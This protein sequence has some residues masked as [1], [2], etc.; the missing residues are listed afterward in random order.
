LV[1]CLTKLSFYLHSSRNEKGCNH[2][3]STGQEIRVGVEERG[4]P[5]IGHHQV[6]QTAVSRLIHRRCHGAARKK[7]D[8][9]TGLPITYK[10]VIYDSI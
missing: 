6:V 8:V 1:I 10:I 3:R 5:K 4:Q 9:I 7:R 2:D